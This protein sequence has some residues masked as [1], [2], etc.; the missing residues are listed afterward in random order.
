[1]VKPLNFVYHEG[2]IYFHSACQGEKIDDI[3]RD[4][5]VCFEVDLPV[6][7]VKGRVDNPCRASYL[8][9]SVIVRGNARLVEDE[10]ERL[11]ALD[12]LMRK[13]QPEGGYGPYLE[14]KL[15][16]T[17]VIRIDIEGFSGKEELGKEEMRERVLALLSGNTPLPVVME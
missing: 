10:M 16:L 12:A 15:E 8:Y 17:A 11:A 3:R 6:A 14:E 4:Q 9:Q 2:A 1:M 13:Y 5:R 7:Y